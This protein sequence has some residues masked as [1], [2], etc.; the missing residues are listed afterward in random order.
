MLTAIIPAAGAGRRMHSTVNKQFLNIT[1]QPVLARTL[2][3]LQG[4]ADKYVIVAR[5]GEEGRC[6]DVAGAVIDSFVVVTGGETR[7]KSVYAG[8]EAARGSKYVLIHDGCRPFA[9]REMTLQLIAVANE[10]GAAIPVL[11]VVDTIKEVEGDFVQSTL[12]RQRLRAVQT[13]Q[14]FRWELIWQAHCRAKE[15]G[16]EATDDAALVEALGYRVAVVEGSPDNVKI[17]TPS[18]LERYN[19][20]ATRVGTG[21]DVHRLEQGRPLVLGGVVIPHP[22]GLAGH[23]DAD[24]L[25]HAVIDALLG[26]AALGDIGRHFPDTDDA[27]RDISSLKLLSRT[28]GLLAEAG[29]SVVNIDATIVAQQPKLAPYIDEMR[30]S[31]AAVLDLAPAVVSIKATTTEGLG[32]AGRREGIAAQAVCSIITDKGGEM[33]CL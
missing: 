12:P 20:P 2:L 17:T 11:P 10:R 16:I 25:V 23:S 7:Q 1:G 19:R 14:V 21:Y 26:A 13:P 32:L 24:V 27:L 15:Q 29:F 6:R 4:I 9:P 5:A 28:A 33:R 8:L 30:R 18:D 22:Y 31:V 3:S